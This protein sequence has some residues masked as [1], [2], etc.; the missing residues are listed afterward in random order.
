MQAAS[1]EG[2]FPWQSF[3]D[4][5]PGTPPYIRKQAVRNAVEFCGPDRLLFGSDSMLPGDFTYQRTVRTADL[6]LY[7]ELG[8][9]PAQIERVMSG[10][11]DQL[12]P[13]RS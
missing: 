1:R 9:Q 12:F 4:T 7:G 3:I 13:V 6:T 2:G 5:T 11:A 8:L 10:T